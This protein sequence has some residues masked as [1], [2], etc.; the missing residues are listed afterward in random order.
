[1]RRAKLKPYEI[2]HARTYR[3][4]KSGYK[5]KNPI[6]YRLQQSRP[7]LFRRVFI[8]TTVKGIA[9]VM[10]IKCFQSLLIHQGLLSLYL[11]GAACAQ[12]KI[13]GGEFSSFVKGVQSG[14]FSRRLYKS[15][16]III[17]IIP[18]QL[19]P[20][21]PHQS[22]FVR[23]PTLMYAQTKIPHFLVFYSLNIL[24]PPTFSR[25][26][27]ACTCHWSG[28]AA[29]YLQ[30]EEMVETNETSNTTLCVCTL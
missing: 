22:A 14:T 25:K 21:Q 20:T 26:H 3:L 5:R 30:W 15:I 9:L 8:D 1:M 12:W 29:A 10:C 4:K 6:T 19:A 17:I 24:L 23:R 28:C 11:L 18:H 2:S 27:P 16:T 13:G 7:I